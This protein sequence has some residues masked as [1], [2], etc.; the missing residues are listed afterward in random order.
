MDTEA[1]DEEGRPKI[2]GTQDAWTDK[3]QDVLEE[4]DEPAAD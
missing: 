2:E 1:L 3:A 4:T